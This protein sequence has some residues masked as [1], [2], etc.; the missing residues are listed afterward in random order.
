MV[1]GISMYTMISYA[2]FILNLMKLYLCFDFLLLWRI[3]FHFV[4]NYCI[5]YKKISILMY[6][7]TSTVCRE[8]PEITR[9]RS[10]LKV[11]QSPKVSIQDSDF[12]TVAHFWIDTDLLVIPSF[13]WKYGPSENKGIMH[14][15]KDKYWGLASRLDRD[16]RRSRR[17][18]SWREVNPKCLSGIVYDS[19]WIANT[20]FSYCNTVLTLR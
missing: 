19:I 14:Y 18:L 15:V 1:V 11:G 17:S 3:I 16:R 4:I 7:I 13:Y 6:F 20:T 8:P 10:L 9:D 12:W 2:K 5:I